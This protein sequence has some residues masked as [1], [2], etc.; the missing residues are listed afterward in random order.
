MEEAKKVFE[1]LIT[2]YDVADAL[3]DNGDVEE[4]VNMRIKCYLKIYGK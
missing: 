4:S 1:E 2:L 3:E